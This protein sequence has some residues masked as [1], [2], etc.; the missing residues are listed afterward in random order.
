MIL[1]ICSSIFQTLYDSEQQKLGKQPHLRSPSMSLPEE[2]EAGTE[3]YRGIVLFTTVKP[4]EG[5][6]PRM[7]NWKNRQSLDHRQIKSDQVQV[8]V[9]SS[10]AGRQRELLASID[11]KKDTWQEHCCGV[12]WIDGCW[13]M[14][15]ERLEMYNGVPSFH[16]AHHSR[17]YK[18]PGF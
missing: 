18:F 7:Q 8:Q 13:K 14:K 1:R 2:A 9:T 6:H 17:A 16:L 5:W 15:D 12:T 10:S 11:G 4:N 3:A